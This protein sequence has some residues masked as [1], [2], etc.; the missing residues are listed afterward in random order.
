[1]LQAVYKLLLCLL[2][3]AC[4][5]LRPGGCQSG[6]LTLA[7]FAS[8]LSDAQDGFTGNLD[9][10]PFMAAVDM[11]LEMVNNNS[12]ILPGYNLTSLIK[13]S[14]VSHL[15]SKRLSLRLSLHL[16][17]RDRPSTYIGCCNAG[18]HIVSRARLGVL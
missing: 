16:H 14:R 18:F 1:M 15:T 4:V 2:L 7:V 11:A 17:I 10:R 5:A 9:G 13:D 12:E 8:G 3:L 6:E